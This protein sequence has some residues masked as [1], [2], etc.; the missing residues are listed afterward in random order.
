MHSAEPAFLAQHR[1]RVEQLLHTHLE[2]SRAPAR[3]QEAINYS[4]FSGGKRIRPIL[5]Y[6]TA[7]AL[8]NESAGVDAAA[9]AV[10]LIHTYS[11]IHDDL[12]CMDDDDLRRGK[13]TV[14]VAFDEA[15]A[16]LAGDAM[17]AMAFELLSNAERPA[18]VVLQMVREL[19]L[20]SGA[21]GMVA[22]QMIDLE[23]TGVAIDA[24]T[25]E[26]MHRC[27]TGALIK[28]SVRLAALCCN[29]SD[30]RMA[31]LDLYADSIGLAFQV[32][33]DILDVEGSEAIM[34]KKRGADSSLHKSTY[35]SLHGLQDAKAELQ[36]LHQ[37][38]IESLQ[39]LGPAA[40]QLC[41][42]ADLV[43]SRSS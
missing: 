17:Q 20:A 2:N 24:A 16:V 9:C 7:A 31:Q 39:S 43:V 38:S 13:P 36:Q 35:V 37:T 42:L 4:L 1:S 34:G 14:H 8:G 26:A 30:Q 40:A 27:K 23:S 18:D 3:L 5:A 19:A 21:E 25:L 6:A 11:L 12:P 15:T 41:S 32:K 22:G 10:E 28:A 33:D 29:P